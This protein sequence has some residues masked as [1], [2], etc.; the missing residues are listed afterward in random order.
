MAR[1]GWHV[2]VNLLLAIIALAIMRLFCGMR[3]SRRSKHV[4]K[5]T[6]PETP[7]PWLKMVSMYLRCRSDS[8]LHMVCDEHIGRV[9]MGNRNHF[10]NNEFVLLSCQALFFY[11]LYHNALCWTYL[12]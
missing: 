8:L 7:A 2:I 4:C 9:V 3:S 10:K 5:G 6:C 1:F 12:Q 11:R